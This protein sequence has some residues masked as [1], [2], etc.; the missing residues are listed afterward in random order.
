MSNQDKDTR[1]I[2][3]GGGAYIEGSVETGG[4][5]F[6]GRDQTKG[7]SSHEVKSIL[8]PLMEVIQNAPPQVS[9]EALRK[10]RISKTRYQRVRKLTIPE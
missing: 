8:A 3:T 7:L 9:S 2:E 10:C 1:K 5:D 6:V 4:G